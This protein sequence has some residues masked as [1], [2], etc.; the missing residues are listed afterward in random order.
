MDHVIGGRF[1]LGRKIGS[2]SFGELYLVN[3]QTGEEVAVKLWKLLA[4]HSSE[5]VAKI[6]HPQ[7]GP[8][9][10][11]IYEPSLLRFFFLTLIKFCC[12]IFQFLVDYF[13]VW[14]R[15]AIETI[16]VILCKSIKS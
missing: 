13:L 8:T 12:K 15:G 4:K 6:G 10:P 14:F 11:S 9:E 16:L 1:K 7:L 5:M 3:I 2:E